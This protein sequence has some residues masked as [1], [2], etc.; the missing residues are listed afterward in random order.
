MAVAIDGTAEMIIP[1]TSRV[2]CILI[3]SAAAR[4]VELCI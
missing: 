1:I 4:A 3:Y 2:W